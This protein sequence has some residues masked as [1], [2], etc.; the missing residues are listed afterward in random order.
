MTSSPR[1]YC[2]EQVGALV[3][4]K[5]IDFLLDRFEPTLLAHIRD[6]LQFEPQL[7]VLPWLLCI[8]VDALPIAAVARIIDCLMFE[9]QTEDLRVCHSS[10][11]LLLLTLLIGSDVLLR[12]SMALFHIASA[13]I[14]ACKYGPDLVELMRK[15]QWDINEILH[16]TKEKKF[17]LTRRSS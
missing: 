16:V 4:A 8:F 5:V 9:G 17:P 15:R 3:E 1:V 11:N 10:E 12:V 13:E 2:L 6:A 7:L 14:L